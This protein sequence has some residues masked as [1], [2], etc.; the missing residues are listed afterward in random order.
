MMMDA[1]LKEYIGC[2]Y[3]GEPN[4]CPVLLGMIYAKGNPNQ[5]FHNIEWAGDLI[6]RN[7]DLKAAEEETGLSELSQSILVG[8]AS[9]I[10]TPDFNENKYCKSCGRLRGCSKELKQIISH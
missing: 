10:K 3:Q 7:L 5:Q 4:A 2:S 6:F 9:G 8:F 1:R